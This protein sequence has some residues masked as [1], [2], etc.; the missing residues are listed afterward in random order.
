MLKAL[1]HRLQRQVVDLKVA[2]GIA[3]H[4]ERHVGRCFLR[5]RERILPHFDQ[6]PCGDGQDRAGNDYTGADHR[7]WPPGH[8]FGPPA[9]KA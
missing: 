1:N 8:V 4:Q 3:L 9:K 6:H 5:P 2:R 7:I